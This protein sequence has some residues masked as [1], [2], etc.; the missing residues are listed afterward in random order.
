MNVVILGQFFFL[1][2]ISPLSIRWAFRIFFRISFV[3]H[4]GRKLPKLN[5]KFG[6]GQR[7]LVF[8]TNKAH[9]PMSRITGFARQNCW[10]FLRQVTYEKDLFKEYSII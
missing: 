6:S 8:V 10:S 1:V 2:D 4:R 9:P 3:E 5:F 7:I